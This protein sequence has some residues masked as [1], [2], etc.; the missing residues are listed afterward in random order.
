[1][2]KQ[3]LFDLTGKVAVVSGAAQG[4]GRATAVAVA[5]FGADMMLVDR[6]LEGAEATAATYTWIA[7]V[8]TSACSAEARGGLPLPPLTS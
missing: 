6:N 5:Q 3:A 7:S 2:T 1:M 8:A 4:M